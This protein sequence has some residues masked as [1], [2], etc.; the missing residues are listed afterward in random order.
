[1]GKAVEKPMKIFI[2]VFEPIESTN[3]SLAEAFH[4][5]LTDA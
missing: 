4:K 5:T 1:M 3:E 2:L